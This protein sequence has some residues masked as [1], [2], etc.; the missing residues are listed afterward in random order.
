[1]SEDVP[2]FRAGESSPPGGGKPLR[3]AWRVVDAEE[4]WQ[5]VLG[6]VWGDQGPV[7]EGLGSRLIMGS[8]G[9]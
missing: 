9:D 6:Q 1:M 8:H 3:K 4:Q 2:C 7:C 5:W